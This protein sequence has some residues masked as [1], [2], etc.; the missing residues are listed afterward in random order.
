MEEQ[1]LLSIFGSPFVDPNSSIGGLYISTARYRILWIG[2]GAVPRKLVFRG[3]QGLRQL[4]VAKVSPDE[5]PEAEE[6]G[7]TKDNSNPRE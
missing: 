6:K 5:G 4:R 3:G 7:T 1:D 2:S